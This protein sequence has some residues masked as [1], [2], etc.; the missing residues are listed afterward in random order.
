MESATLSERAITFV[1]RHSQSQQEDQMPHQL[2]SGPQRDWQHFHIA[3]VD[4]LWRED[5][6]AGEVEAEIGRAHV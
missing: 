5:R 1:T 4:P 3:V 2:A 6:K